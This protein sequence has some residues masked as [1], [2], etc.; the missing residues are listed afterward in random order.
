MVRELVNTEA[1]VKVWGGGARDGLKRACWVTVVVT[2]GWS[3]PPLRVMSMNY[4]HKSVPMCVTCPA[5]RIAKRPVMS[6]RPIRLRP[7]NGNPKVPVLCIGNA[8]RAFCISPRDLHPKRYFRRWT[9]PIWRSCKILQQWKYKLCN[10]LIG[11]IDPPPT[12]NSIPL[13]GGEEDVCIRFVKK[14]REKCLLVEKKE[15]RGVVTVTQSRDPPLKT[16]SLSLFLPPCLELIRPTT[17]RFFIPRSLGCGVS[18]GECK[19][20]LEYYCGGERGES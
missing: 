3:D 1:R 7:V 2:P 18:K 19:L 10:K 14:R 13:R 12:V 11:C 8:P 6:I 16:L 4:T 17:P 5:G 20:S 15:R 9:L